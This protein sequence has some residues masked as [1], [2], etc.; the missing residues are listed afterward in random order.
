METNSTWFHN[1]IDV[2]STYCAFFRESTTLGSCS[3]YGPT[4]PLI[5]SSCHTLTSNTAQENIIL[6]LDHAFPGKYPFILKY[7]H[8]S[9]EMNIPQVFQLMGELSTINTSTTY[10]ELP[11]WGNINGNQTGRTA[12][13]WDQN[14]SNLHSQEKQSIIEIQ[15]I[16]SSNYYVENPL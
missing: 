4:A 14:P 15:N 6:N 1:I 16:V 8:R 13:Y 7:H 9:Y 12:P 2:M 10:R 11:L 5:R 3:P